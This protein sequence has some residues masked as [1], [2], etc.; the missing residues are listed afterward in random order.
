MEFTFTIGIFNS[1]QNF[2]SLGF[3]PLVCGYRYLRCSCHE[4]SPERGRRKANFVPSLSFAGPFDSIFIHRFLA[5]HARNFSHLFQIFSKSRF[6]QQRQRTPFFGRGF[7]N[8]VR[9]QLW[10]PDT[11][12]A[13]L[14]QF[15]GLLSDRPQSRSP[16]A[17]GNRR[18]SVSHRP[19]N[20][21]MDPFLLWIVV[22]CSQASVEQHSSWWP[23]GFSILDLL[24]N[25][26]RNTSSFTRICIGFFP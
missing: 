14:F 20:L 11:F 24:Q 8:F 21:P 17:P 15:F 7:Y 6:F 4:M 19:A 10:Y 18:R 12:G 5:I 1:Y 13:S 2:D 25:V 9:C 3:C 16:S 22:L 23:T 26:S